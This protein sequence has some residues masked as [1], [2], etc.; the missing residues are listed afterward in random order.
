MV[1]MVRSGVARAGAC[2]LAVLVLVMTTCAPLVALQPA[3]EAQTAP[4]HTGG[5]AN[6]IL[7]DLGQ[8]SFQGINGRT[9]PPFP[10][11]PA[12]QQLC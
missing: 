6:L 5:E 7:P 9:L 12:D 11:E 4:R 10:R 1:D 2:W 3:Q 8:V